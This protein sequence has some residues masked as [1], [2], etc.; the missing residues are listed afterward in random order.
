MKRLLVVGM[1]LAVASL[2]F[3]GGNPWVQ[4]YVSFDQSGSGGLDHHHDTIQYVG[5]NAFFCF[6]D[7]DM[8]LT[9]VSFMINDPMTD[10][11]ACLRVRA[12]RTC[13]TSWSAIRSR[14]C[15]WHHR[16]AGMRR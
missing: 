11:R 13:W 14:A 3:A 7:L 5:F 10:C 6:T 16:P 1:V 4:C 12:S 9:V 15:H 2:A 8:G